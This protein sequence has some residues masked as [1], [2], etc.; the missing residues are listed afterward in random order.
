M[1]L[2]LEMGCWVS[3]APLLLVNPREEYLYCDSLNWQY[4]KKLSYSLTSPQSVVEA[5]AIQTKGK[6]GSLVLSHEYLM[7]WRV[8]HDW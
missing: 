1:I 3:F 5:S 6:A 2:H 8:A 7:Q 4:A